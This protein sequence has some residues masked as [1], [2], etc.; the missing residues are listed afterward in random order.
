MGMLA[1]VIA[2]FI[3]STLLSGACLW[4]AMKI[5]RVNGTFIAAA[6]IAAISSLVGFLPVVGTILS[7]VVMFVLICKWTDAVLMV[8]VSGAIAWGARAVIYGILT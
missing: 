3:V 5:I 1:I 8:L 4:L 7:A 2:A 6:S